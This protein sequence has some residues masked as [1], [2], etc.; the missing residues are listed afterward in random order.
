MTD[1]EYEELLP[2]SQ[3]KRET[4]FWGISGAFIGMGFSGA[5]VILDDAAGGH[6]L[7]TAILGYVCCLLFMWRVGL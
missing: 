3:N 5:V 6:V 1:T 2:D 4:W 7:V